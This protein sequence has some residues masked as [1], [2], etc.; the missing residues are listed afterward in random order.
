M[1]PGKTGIEFV[2]EV[3]QNPKFEGTPIIMLTT[4]G[5]IKEMQKGKAAGANS[6]LT[7]PV[8]R[9]RLEELTTK[10]L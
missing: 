6:W 2:S 8:D 3:R 9:D 4:V 1:M 7:K 10:Y 5:K